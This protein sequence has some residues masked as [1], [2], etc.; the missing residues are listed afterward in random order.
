METKTEKAIRRCM[1]RSRQTWFSI[2]FRRIKRWFKK[3]EIIDSSKYNLIPWN[4]MPRHCIMSKKEYE[5]SEKIRKEKGR[6]KYTFEYNGIGHVLHV[7]TEDG[8]D[9]DITDFDCW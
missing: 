3:W 9:F 6:L 4:E 5:M 1:R 2:I 7:T 8:E